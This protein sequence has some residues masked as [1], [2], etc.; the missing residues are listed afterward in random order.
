[1]G[2]WVGGWEGR[3]V[4]FVGVWEECCGSVARRSMI[5]TSVGVREIEVA[6]C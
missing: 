1:V 6:A 3:I 5:A 2:G 4:E